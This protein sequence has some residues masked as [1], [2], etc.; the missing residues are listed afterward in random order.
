MHVSLKQARLQRYVCF[1]P[2]LIVQGQSFFSHLRC[3]R[4]LG[5]PETS[6]VDLHVID[7]RYVFSKARRRHADAARGHRA[8]KVR[9]VEDVA[10]H[11]HGQIALRRLS[12]A[13][14]AASA[15]DVV[16]EGILGSRALRARRRRCLDYVSNV[17]HS[18]AGLNS[19]LS[20]L[21]VAEAAF[22]ALLRRTPDFITRALQLRVLA[23]DRE[24]LTAAGCLR[25]RFVLLRIS[26][27]ESANQSWPAPARCSSPLKQRVEH[28]R[29]HP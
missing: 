21:N 9:V 13:G 23:T 14:R 11:L 17:C 16:V 27:T 22:I 5:E 6:C 2:S 29:S 7:R 12:V 24:L 26:D 10:H 28:G 19:S 8:C 15:P 18:N 1:H 20:S 4:R 3:W 25:L